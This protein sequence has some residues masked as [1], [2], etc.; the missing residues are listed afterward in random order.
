[1]WVKQEVLLKGVPNT[2]ISCSFQS[3]LVLSLYVLY[4]YIY[5]QHR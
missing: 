2:L 4:M 3:F 1:M 5:I